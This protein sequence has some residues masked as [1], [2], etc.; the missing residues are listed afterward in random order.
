MIP[1]TSPCCYPLWQRAPMERGVR[2]TAVLAGL[3]VVS[4]RSSNVKRPC[5]VLVD[6]ARNSFSVKQWGCSPAT[7][8]GADFRKTDAVHEA[9]NI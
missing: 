5:Q 8:T 9:M 7:D 2:N 4:I 6:F 3:I 1:A